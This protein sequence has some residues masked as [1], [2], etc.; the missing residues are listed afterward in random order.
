MADREVAE[1]IVEVPEIPEVLE[2]ALLFALDEAKEIMERGDD[3][4]PFTVL[5]VNDNSIIERHSGESTDECFSLAQHT[6]EGA[7]GADA[8]AFCYD[9]YI[10]M[11]SG[12]QD[13]LI[14]EGGV[15][16]AE[17]GHAVC[18]LYKRED[19]ENENEGKGESEGD[20]ESEGEGEGEGEGS[21]TF[22][23]DPAY[24]GKAPNFMSNLGESS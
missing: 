24:V 13:A 7:R 6:V 21:L 16:G 23:P 9:G 5:V 1:E 22:E 19:A 17:E 11:D 18:Y 8:Y 3:L 2:G 14:A 12:V 15:P 4:I 10:E 20:G